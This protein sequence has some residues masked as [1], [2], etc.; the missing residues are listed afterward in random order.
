MTS[1]VLV[2]LMLSLELLLLG[3]HLCE[4]LK[5]LKL[6]G[7]RQ[8]NLIGKIVAVAARSRKVLTRLGQLADDS[9]FV[10]FEL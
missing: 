1:L 9:L 4:V 10:H 5:L 6:L 8:V 2:F 7:L 3:L